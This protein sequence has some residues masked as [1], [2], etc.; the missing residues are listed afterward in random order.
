MNINK[1]NIGIR[2]MKIGKLDSIDM[3]INE[4]ILTLRIDTT[5]NI[6]PSASGKTIMIASSGGNKKINV[7]T[8]EA[9]DTIML[10]L[11]IYRYPEN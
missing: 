2:E 11:N 1:I 6:G 4:G 9:E 7:G 5:T 8:D 3:E 10:G